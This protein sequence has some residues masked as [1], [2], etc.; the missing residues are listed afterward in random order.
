MYP[1]DPATVAANY[2]D[3]CNNVTVNLTDTTQTGDDCS[4]TLVYTYNVVDDCGNT[5]ADETITYSGSDQTAPTGTAPVGDTNVDVCS[6]DAQTV[7]PFDPA[8]VAA[9]YSDNC[10]NVTVNLTNTQQTGDDCSWTLVYTYNVVD[11][12][13]NTLADETITYS[14]S[15]QTAP[16]GT[17]PVGDT[18]VDVCSADAQTVYP[19]DPATVAANYSDNCNNVTVNLTDT[20]QTG[21]DC[22]WTLVYT[23]NVVD[24]CG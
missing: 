8:T 1:F 13:G 15:D 7:Y 14:G 20:T 19:F 11:D 5:L 3:N 24:D 12:C 6:A 4:W 16:T 21:D 17:A 18:N 22:S 2:S 10:N 23:Y 9:N